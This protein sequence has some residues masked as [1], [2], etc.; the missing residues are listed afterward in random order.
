MSAEDINN[1]VD[2]TPIELP[3]TLV[4]FAEELPD[5]YKDLKYPLDALGPILGAAAKRLAYHVQVPEGMAGQSVLAAAALIAQA[6]IDVQRGSI[7]V[8][9]VSIFCLSVAESCP[10]GNLV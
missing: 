10:S 8:G 4:D 5:P 3:P 1:I 7:G 2:D 6:H 9:P